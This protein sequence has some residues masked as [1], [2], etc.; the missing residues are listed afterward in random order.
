MN[1]SITIVIFLIAMIILNSC[2]EILDVDDADGSVFTQE[3]RSLDGVKL[4][5]PDIA[6]AQDASSFQ[7]VRYTLSPRSRLLLR[8]ENL[9]DLSGEVIISES[10]RMH[11]QLSPLATQDVDGLRAG[12]KLCPLLKNWMML[13]T[14]NQAHPFPGGSGS[15]ATP[16]GDFLESECLTAEI[17][18]EDLPRENIYFDVSDWF[19]YYNQSRASNFGWVLISDAAIEIY[20]DNHVSKAPRLIWNIVR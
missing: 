3:I 13:A 1:N 5:S 8:L 4:I 7:E 12:V 18:S 14:W 17:P 19:G 15:W 9:G 2:G 16:G 20:G 6:S 11:F 10:K